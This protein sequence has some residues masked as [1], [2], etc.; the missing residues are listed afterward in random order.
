[1]HKKRVLFHSEASYLRSGYSVITKEV[2]SRLHE[3][4]DVAEFSNYG[5]RDFPNRH[6]IPWTYYGNGCGENWMQP[7]DEHEAA[8]YNSTPYNHFG[9]DKIEDALLHF[10]P[11]VYI[12]PLD[13][14]MYMC[15]LNSPLRNNFKTIIIPTIDASSYNE[16]WISDYISSDYVYT[17]TQFAYNQL[18]EIK[19]INLAG[20][21]SP[22]VSN[23]T[24]LPV[25]NKKAHKSSYGLPENCKIVGTVMRNQRRKLYPDLFEGFRK[26]LQLCEEKDKELGRNTYLYIHTSYPDLGWD[27]CRLIKEY[28]LS[29][30][31]L[32]T[33][34]CHACGAAHAS[35]F[36]DV[37]KVCMNCNQGACRMPTTTLG[38]EEPA[39][40]HIYNLFDIYIQCQSMEGFG[41]P[42]VEAA[43]AGVHPMVVDYSGPED[44]KETLKATPTKVKA[45]YR[46][47]DSGRQ[48]AVPDTDDIALK[49]FNVLSLPEQQLLKMGFDARKGVITHYTW[50]KYAK[51]LEASIDEVPKGWTKPPRI[52]QP[53]LNEP[54][55]LQDRDF[56]QWS[57]VN[58]LGEPDKLNTYF[59]SLLLKDL[60]TGTSQ[61]FNDTFLSEETVAS[62]RQIVQVNRDG[63]KRKLLDMVNKRN[64][65]ES[66][67]FDPNYK[68]PHWIEKSI[69]K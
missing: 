16:G 57:I 55:G 24:F 47:A 5:H 45:F 51:N 30:K 59:A 22:G 42:I 35:F 58:I 48:V 38:L 33:Y 1:M 23:K 39:L 29:H 13:P 3:K 44:F 67:R 26:Y 52:T 18:K 8:V 4:Y 62:T 53:N 41:I 19:Q 34:I 12:S 21:C 20:I 9:A 11:D 60:S 28:G 68:T 64:M 69:Q 36:Q 43:S 46:E 66:R 25:P 14:W 10:K 61:T 31:I 2:L 37:T 56:I 49:L 6:Q 63:I 7:V 65:W 40:N 27:L 17:Y 50:D 54:Q 15:G 32:T